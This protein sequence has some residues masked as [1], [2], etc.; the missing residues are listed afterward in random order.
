MAMPN[1]TE[2]WAVETLD[3]FPIDV[4]V[5]FTR[6]FWPG[7]AE[8]IFSFISWLVPGAS[9]TS[10][11]RETSLSPSMRLTIQPEGSEDE[12]IDATSLNWPVFLT[13]R[14]SFADSSGLEIVEAVLASLMDRLRP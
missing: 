4:A 1:C 14:S 3:L 9:G 5:M 13:S 11:G 7:L 8:I 2:A 10:Y 6:P 12:F